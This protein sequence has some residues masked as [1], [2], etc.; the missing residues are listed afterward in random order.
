MRHQTAILPARRVRAYSA[1]EGECFQGSD[2]LLRQGCVLKYAWFDAQRKAYR[3][4]VMCEALTV[5]ISGYS[6]PVQFRQDR[7]T[8]QQERKMAA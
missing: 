8:K 7:I 2:G 4:S 5:S 6:S 3:R 1:G